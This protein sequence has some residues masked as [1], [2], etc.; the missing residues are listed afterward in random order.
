MRIKWLFPLLASLM[1]PSVAFAAPDDRIHGRIVVDQKDSASDSDTEALVSDLRGRFS[2]VSLEKTALEK[3][4]KIEILHVDP[5]DEDA[6]ISYLQSKKGLESVEPLYRV[7]AYGLANFATPNDPLYEKQWSFKTVEAEKSWGYNRGEGVVIAIVDTGIDCSLEDF[8]G[9]DCRHGWNFIDDTDDS[10]DD[11]SH[12]SHVASTCAEATNNNF[13]AAGLANK[14]TLLGVK[15]LSASG[16]GTS[17]GVADGIRWAADNGANVIN[18]SLGGPHSSKVQEDAVKYALEKGVVVVAANGNDSGPIGYPAGYAGVI[19]VSATDSD[20]TVADFS[21]RGPQ[22][23]IGAPGVNIVQQ[24]IPNDRGDFPAYSG[25]SMAT[26]HVAAA[27]ALLMS[28]GVTDPAEVKRYL[29]DGATKTMKMRFDKDS[30]GAGVLSAGNSVSKAASHNGWWRFIFTMMLMTFTLNRKVHK[31]NWKF[32]LPAV[33]VGCG[34]WF[35]PTLVSFPS[36]LTFLVSK[37]LV[38]ATALFSVKL[39][40]YLPLAN[41]LLPGGLMALGWHRQSLRLPIAGVATG[42]AGYLSQ[43]LWNG[44]LALPFGTLFS[45]LF[46]MVNGGICVYLAKFCLEHLTSKEEPTPQSTIGKPTV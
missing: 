41:A 2:S 8:K 28:Q 27:A 12:G 38:E 26:P 43:L 6:V 45:T 46:L 5:K 7:E 34:V 39:T 17:E 11:Q 42:V 9:V 3:E 32:V 33:L 35:L 24:T 14:S 16:S 15:T 44:T 40:N 25:T 10:T 37:P 29:A 19:A 1:F 31:F 30:Y 20:N 23:F 22:T 21:S 18:L 4:T 13:G 36:F